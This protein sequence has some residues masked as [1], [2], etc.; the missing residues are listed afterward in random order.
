MMLQKFTSKN[1]VL[2]LLLFFSCGILQAQ[3][4]TAFWFAVPKLTHNHA[5]HPIRLVVSAL[6]QNATV[7]VTMPA[8]TNP[9][10]T[11]LNVNAGQSAT[12]QFVGGGQ[13]TAGV[14]TLDNI[15]EYECNHNATS[16]RGIYI[17]STAKIN[18]YISVMCNN[19]EIYALKGNNGL[20]TKFFI[21]MQFSFPNASYTDP[22]R[23]SVEI[24]AT[25]DNTVVQITPTAALYGGQPAN[26]TFSVTLNRGQVYSF[27]SA[28]QTANGHLAGTIVTSNKP[29]VVDISDDSVTPNNSNQDLVADQIVPEDMAGT[30]YIVIP[31]PSEASNSENS[32][33]SDYAYIFALEDNTNVTVKSSTNPSP[34]TPTYSNL[35]RGSKKAYHFTDNNA[36]YIEADKP[37]LVFQLT[38]AGNEVGGTL[39]PHVYCTGSTSVS[40]TPMASYHGHTKYIYLTLICNPAFKSGFNITTG[41]QTVTLT[42]SDWKTV[43]GHVFNYCCKKITNTSSIIKVN[44]SLGKFQMGVIDW[45]GSYDDCSISYFSDYDSGNELTWNTSLTHSDYC[46]G[47]T[48]NFEFDTIDIKDLAVFGPN[49]FTLENGAQMVFTNPDPSYSG[50][51]VVQGWD[52]RD[53]LND[54]F[55]DTIEIVIHSNADTIIKDTICL[56]DTYTKYGF[57]ISADTTKIPGL[58]YDSLKLET[59]QYGCDSIVYLQ[60]TVRDSIKSL[61]YDTACIEYV[62]NNVTYNASG[63]YKQVLQSIDGCDSV[64][65]L[66]LNIVVPK[67]T[68]TTEDDFCEHDEANLTANS[69]FSN[70]VWSTGETTQSIVATAPQKYYVTVTDDDGGCATTTFFEIQPCSF[71]IFLPTAFSPDSRIQ[72]NK[73]FS[74]APAVHKFINDEGFSIEIYNRW[75][76]L[77]FYSDKKDFVWRA[78]DVPVSQV[79][80][81][82]IRYYDLG[83]KKQYVQRGE[84]TVL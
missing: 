41:T 68:I 77:V 63:S 30:M 54:I 50:T 39:L 80:V 26:Q 75:G 7:T 60:L 11:T 1:I 18:A 6:D 58:H 73:T 10:I 13:N 5:G 2:A 44:N 81:Y 78:E 19:S 3:I 56:G 16:N 64:V 14:V 69:D 25:E 43:P 28:S 53:C 47:E 22:A 48:I 20:G 24:I 52:A 33:M 74:I 38:G 49:N 71:N 29:I 23:N 27:A 34:L 40:Y 12:Y 31:S 21:P 35:N 70:Y 17:H 83:G 62:W 45:N 9:N 32:S 76:S 66:N 4:D 61:F 8:A 46:Q 72:E 65:T 79:Y 57:N 15:E 42:N 67:V 59:V 37:I 51:Y 84:V 36:V 82:I 55:T